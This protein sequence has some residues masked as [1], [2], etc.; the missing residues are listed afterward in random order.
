MDRHALICRN[1][2][3]RPQITQRELAQAMDI[4]LGSTNRL[5][6]ECLERN[7]MVVLA[8]GRY[9]ITSE[10]RE[11]LEP[12]RVDG[13]VI[14]AAGF[15]SRFVPLTFETPKGLLEVFGERMIERQIRQLHQA[16]VT[17]IT[18]VV[19]YLKEKF[20]YLIDKYNVK[21]LYNREYA[22]KNT[23]ATIYHARRLFKGRNMY[24][25]AS[26]NWMRENMYHA[27]EC[28]SWYSSVYQ[29]GDTS[30]WCLSFNKKG[31]ISR[32]EIGGR[33]SWV[34]YGP[35]F[36][37]KE[38]SE[39]Y[40]P[41]L[42]AYYSIP[43]TEQFHW[44]N[45]Y[46]DLVNGTALRRL[47]ESGLSHLQGRPLKEYGPEQEK[48][49][50]YINRQDSRQVYEFENLE[51]LRRFDTRYQNHSDNEAM[52]L[53][54]RVLHIPE[55]DIRHI[56]CLKSGMTNQSFLFSVSGKQYICRIPGPGTEFLINRRQEAAV[57]DAVQPLGITEHV[58][59]LNGEN[60]YKISEYY[61]GARNSDASSW[62]DVNRCMALLRQVHRADIH[63]EHRFNIRERIEFYEKLCMTHGGIPV[64][65]YN[66]VKEKMTDLMD[67]LDAMN[68]P[69]TLS[70]IDS[71]ADNFLF[72][73]DGSLRLIDWEY[74]GMCDPLIDVAM[75]AIYSYYDEEQTDH[76]IDLYLER[77]PTA[78]E[79]AVIYSYVALGGF[80]WSLWAVYKSHIGEEFGE[81]TLIMYRY[82]KRYYNRMQT[83][84]PQ[85]ASGGSV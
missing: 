26:D 31:K 82:A 30:E 7:L 76:L 72:L 75:C 29:E 71:V 65:D 36:F 56:R 4:S 63:V 19:G 24:L 59:Y 74:A 53:V 79:A 62:Q 48:L 23:L 35:A 14:I 50:L 61:D 73:A 27:Y 64:E 40:L 39:Y 66:A 28:C 77:K 68:R 57:Y 37:R 2:L 10:G 17:D 81:Y 9:E 70:H 84:L 83:V 16:G 47:R 58:I 15:G 43:G 69:E 6:K 20:E 12:Y 51:E 21:L 38:W 41:V 25:L 67:R 13:A 60:G 78:Q 3:E 22:S 80:L 5:I 52:E 55:A 42:E 8:D 44:E 32:V 33:D 49:T 1:I 85:A 11:Y 46:M 54:S 18:I 34:M 45:V